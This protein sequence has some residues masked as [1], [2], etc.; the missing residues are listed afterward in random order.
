MYLTRLQ[1]KNIGPFK[2]GEIEFAHNFTDPDQNPVTIITGMNGT[3]KSIVIDAIRAALSNQKLER[4]IVANPDDFLIK[5][6]AIINGKS[7]TVNVAKDSF[8]CLVGADFDIVRPLKYGY[9][10]NDKAQPW[11]VDYWSTRTP[12]DQFE[13]ESIK[14]IDHRTFLKDVML[15]KKSNVDLTNFLCHIDYLRNSDVPEEKSIGSSL[16]QIVTEAINLCLDFGQFKHIRRID[17]QPII[18]QNGHDVTLDK[19]SSGNLFLIEHIVLLISK[20]YSLSVLLNIP[21][22]K[23]MLS[24]GLLLIDEIE[25]HLHPRWQKSILTIL[26]KLFPNMQIILTPHS[27]FILS[28]LRGVSIYTCKPETGR[29]IIVD[30]TETYSNK[31]VEEILLSDAFNVTTFQ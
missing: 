25:N 21:P 2:D 1:L 28:S 16:Y 3:G 18:E 14:R 12:N 10:E 30:E 17:L 9:S 7:N 8:G 19:L 13:I 15:G 24:Q 6:D 22:D 27:P 29:S 4:N 5:I 20:M 31:P 23:I 11:I 26:R